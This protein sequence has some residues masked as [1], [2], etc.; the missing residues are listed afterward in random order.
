MLHVNNLYSVLWMLGNLSGCH[1]LP[2]RSFHLNG[3]QFPVCA[4]CTGAFFGY[5][6]GALV[7][8][9]IAIP[10]WVSLLMCL[11]MFYDWLF[12][13]LDILQS[14]NIRRLITGALCGF[15]LMQMSLSF[16]RF[17]VRLIV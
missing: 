15:G 17:I 13:Y 14:T 1:Q 11:V 4:R 7:F 3:K 12:Q 5:V 2:E 6:L 8:P 9:F 10:Q 16:L